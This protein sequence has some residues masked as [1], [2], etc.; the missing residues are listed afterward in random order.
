MEHVDTVVIGGGQAGLA[1]SYYL[2]QARRDHLVLEKKH[3]ACVWQ[4]ERWDSFALVGP[5][6]MLGLPDMPYRGDDP[7]GFLTRN[8]VIEYLE[9][10]AA[11]V[12]PPILEGVEATA[13]EAASESADLIVRSS[14]GEYRAANV[15]V[16]TGTFQ[17]PKIPSFGT[18]LSRDVQQIHSSQYRNPHHLKPG[19]VLVVGSGQSGCQIAEDLHEQGREVLLSTSRVGR[20][21]RRYRSKDVMCWNE[22]MGVYRMTVDQLPSPADRFAPSYQLSGT[23]GGHTISLHAFS[24][25]GIRLLG[26]VRDGRGGSL[27]IAPDL[28]DNLA[29]ADRAALEFKQGVDRFIRERG[30]EAPEDNEPEARDGYDVPVVTRLNLDLAGIT[31]IIWATGYSFDYSW[32]KFPIFDQS[33]YPVQQRG[34]TPRPGLYFLGLDWLHTV[35]SG[36]LAGVGDDAAYVAEHI[37]SRG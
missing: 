35:L 12:A 37:V 21:P 29:A 28:R 36:T 26:R 3:V 31:T 8:E 20:A 34:V 5:N 6:W 32:V 14:A 15:V 10:F 11:L 4:D 17:R 27:D 18:R 30:L 23:H 7:E 19:A 33:G 24:R 25:D 1:I 9:T 2:T 16:A 13:V 22:L